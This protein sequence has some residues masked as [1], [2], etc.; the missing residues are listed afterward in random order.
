MVLKLKSWLKKDKISK[1][2]TT[3]SS[4]PSSETS[5]ATNGGQDQ[6]SHHRAGQLEAGGAGVDRDQIYKWYVVILEM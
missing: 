1:M 4:A 6:A 2:T 5:G 3:L